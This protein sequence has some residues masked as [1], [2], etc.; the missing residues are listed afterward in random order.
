ML[1][2]VTLDFDGTTADTM[3]KLEEIAVRLIVENYNLPEDTARQK[4]RITTGLPFVQQI[5]ILFPGNPS[6]VK[7][8]TQFEKEKIEGIFEL[9]LFTNAKSTINTLR[10]KGYLVAISS[11]TIQSTIERY[12]EM[13]ELEVDN[14]LGYRE[15]FEKGK[16]HFDFLMKE[17]NLK[18]EEL[19][20]VGDSLKDCERAQNSK[21][22]FI[23]KIGMFSK[24]DFDKIS[25]SKI[26]IVDLEEL[27][28]IIPRINR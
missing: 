16:D 11:S 14:I 10:E 8:I 2:L 20:Y 24:E 4:Y 19:V 9:P 5:N 23:A 21:I 15:G 1:K 26:S 13:R 7:V 6:N 22:L 25:E 12:C 28:E 18:T 27:I 17:F 3:P